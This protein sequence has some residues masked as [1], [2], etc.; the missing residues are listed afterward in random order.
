[1]QIALS[2]NLC[3]GRCDETEMIPRL[4]KAG[5]GGLDFNFCDLPERLDWTNQR[6][7]DP[8][9]DALAESADAHGM[10]WV[11]SHGPMFNMFT[12][13]P[14]DE[15]RRSLII[16][17]LRASS[18][19]G[20]PWMVLHP[21]SLP[22]PHS[23]DYRRTIVEKNVAF[24]RPLLDECEKH[25]VGIAIE[26]GGASMR[27]PGGTVPRGFGSTPEDL[28]ELIDTLDSPWVGLCWDTGHAHLMRLDQHRAIASLDDRLKVL[29]LADNDG[30]RD[31]HVMPFATL[32]GVDWKA[33]TDG[34]RDVGF[35][36][37]FTLEGQSSLRS[38]PDELL[39]EGLRY[40]ADIGKYLKKL[41]TD[42]A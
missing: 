9:L 24:L 2:L 3:V 13:T 11:Q 22:G 31:L 17:A 21:G 33:V 35:A 19:L 16:P 28:C 25:Q 37:A 23:S 20:S 15:H 39:D 5:F 14:H 38:L 7:A 42:G 18:R 27:H 1:M 36:G 34:L 12:E 29:H 4:K 32:G 40:Y 41:V 10:D 30:T 6:E 8:F 26:N